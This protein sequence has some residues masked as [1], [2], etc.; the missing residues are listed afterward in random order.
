MSATSKDV[1]ELKKFIQSLHN[2]CRESFWYKVYDNPQ[3][4]P[5]ENDK[6]Y[7]T[8]SRKRLELLN[9]ASLQK[10]LGLK[11]DEYIALIKNVACYM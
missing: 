4:F 3:D 1:V 9:K 10:H 11:P 8:D 2:Q 6:D 5:D 7:D